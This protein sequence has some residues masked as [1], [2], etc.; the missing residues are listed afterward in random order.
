MTLTVSLLET[1]F[2][3]N[4]NGYKGLGNENYWTSHL[5]IVYDALDPEHIVV[6]VGDFGGRGDQLGVTS[7]SP[8]PKEV[9][10][11]TGIVKYELVP[12]EYYTGNE[13]WDGISY[14]KNIKNIKAR[15]T[16]EI[17]GTALFEMI[18]NRKLKA[19]FFVGKKANEVS[20]FTDN[21]KIY[22]R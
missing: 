9:G 17:R 11:N 14:V 6:S 18:G 19:E 21:A 8:D 12:Y 3:K 10:V 7:N 13:K 2:W 5:S 4:T 22:E 16:N 1:G 15:N 20:G